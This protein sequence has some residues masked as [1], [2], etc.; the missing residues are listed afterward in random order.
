MSFAAMALFYSD[1][2]RIASLNC[3]HSIITG[4]EDAKAAGNARLLEIRPASAILCVCMDI[5]SIDPQRG[6]RLL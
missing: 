2:I 1:G 6:R 3:L 4:F 5:I